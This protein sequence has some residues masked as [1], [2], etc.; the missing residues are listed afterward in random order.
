[1]R[2]LIGTMVLAAMAAAPVA[3]A[4]DASVATP[5][6][7]FVDAFNK[8]DL[9]GVMANYAAGDIAII[10]D[11]A[12]YVWTGPK[13]AQA[14]AADLAKSGTATGVTEGAVKIGS[15]TRTEVAGNF[16]YAI[17]PARYTYKEHG[18][19]MTEE[20]Q[21][22]FALKGGAKAWKVSG[23]TWTGPVPHGR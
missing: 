21:M 6:R 20:G 3:A 19:A 8:G 12:P 11:F 4:E 18:K 7:Q 14:W 16:A 15:P 10:D 22:T 5:L 13:A 23:W 2:I 9:K 1:M 17:V